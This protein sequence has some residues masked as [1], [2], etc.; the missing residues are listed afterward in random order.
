MKKQ[1]DLIL[2][3]LAGVAVY[4]I[5]KSQGG[6]KMLQGL[7]GTASAGLRDVSKTVSEILDQSGK[8]FDNG[9]RYFNDGTVIDP[10]GNYYQGGQLIWSNPAAVSYA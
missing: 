3:G 2:L 9:W 8:A 6:S 5:V 1:S 10:A 4:M 7:T